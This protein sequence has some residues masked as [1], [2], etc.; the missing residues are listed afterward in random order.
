MPDAFDNALR[1]F[2]IKYDNAFA[3]EARRLHDEALLVDYR[4]LADGLVQ[5]VQKLGTVEHAG[6]LAALSKE[7]RRATREAA[8]AWCDIW[9]DFLQALRDFLQ[10]LRLKLSAL[11][12]G[13]K[14][15][16]RQIESHIRKL[17]SSL[18]TMGTKGSQDKKKEL[19]V[20]KRVL[21]AVK[22][23]DA[24]SDVSEDLSWLLLRL[25]LEN[26]TVFLRYFVARGLSIVMR[27]GFRFL[28]PILIFGLLLSLLEHHLSAE[29]IAE[30]P[31]NWLEVG[32]VLLG[33]QIFRYYLDQRIEEWRVKHEAK[34]LR[35]VA[36]QMFFVHA[37][38]LL[39]RTKSRQVP[40]VA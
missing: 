20:Y 21:A 13:T 40:T 8:Q 4:K 9:R 27:F 16:V 3:S 36:F 14:T 33:W 35:P 34:W 31:K 28:I 39:S 15:D 6:A 10:A 11:F 24:R 23:W 32:L 1:E 12:K 2:T 37:A 5:V 17:E 22:K 30:L 18:S 29:W 19:L 7:Y 25:N 26:Y 38:T